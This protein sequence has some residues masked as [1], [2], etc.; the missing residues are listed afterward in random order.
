VLGEI[1][2]RGTGGTIVRFVLADADESLKRRALM[3]TTGGL[4]ACVG[5]VYKPDD[6]IVP[7]TAV[8]LSM[9]STSQI[10]A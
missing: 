3:V 1:L 2:T 10:T 5:A 4:G 8:P 6:E 7:I 9:L